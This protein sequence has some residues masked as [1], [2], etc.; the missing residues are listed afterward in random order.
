M[1]VGHT[2]H[3]DIWILNPIFSFRLDRHQDS[4]PY[5]DPNKCSSDLRFEFQQASVRTL[6]NFYFNDHGKILS[7]LAFFK[8]AE[9]VFC[10]TLFEVLMTGN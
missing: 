4:V 5:D 3:E 9:T 2:N 1:F 7:H 6:N 10:Q 8:E